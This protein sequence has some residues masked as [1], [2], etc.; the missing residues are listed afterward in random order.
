MFKYNSVKYCMYNKH[1]FGVYLLAIHIDV[2]SSKYVHLITS[3][4]IFINFEYPQIKQ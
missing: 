4:L 1:L 3:D 2:K